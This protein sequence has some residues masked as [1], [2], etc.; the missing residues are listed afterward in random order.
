MTGTP[1]L[2]RDSRSFH[3]SRISPPFATRWKGSRPGAAKWQRVASHRQLSPSAW[4]VVGSVQV[5]RV[6]GDR[7]DFPALVAFALGSAEVYADDGVGGGRYAFLRR[8][9][10]GPAEPEAGGWSPDAVSPGDLVH[11]YE[12][13]E[14]RDRTPLLLRS[15]TTSRNTHT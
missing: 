10:R 4:Y 3:A 7:D 5:S 11:Y 6:R 13:I 9:A 15:L 12:A 1:G 2:R 8:P 14:V